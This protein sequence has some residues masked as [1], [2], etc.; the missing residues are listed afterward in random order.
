MMQKK[1][2]VFLFLFL[3]QIC[4]AQTISEIEKTNAFCSIW[5]LLKYQHP[6]VSQGKFNWN[7]Q[8]IVEFN[9]LNEIA[10]YGDFSVEM[11]NWIEK[12]E[13]PR[14]KFKNDANSENK[15][16]KNDEFEWAQNSNFSPELRIVLQK[17]KNNSNIGNYYASVNTLSKMVEVDNDKQYPNFDPSNKA[18]RILFLSSFWNTMK[19]WNVNIYLTDDKWSS[20]LT[21]M[22]YEFKD[23]ANFDNAKDKLFSKLN[24]S[25]AD[26][27]YSRFLTSLKNFPDFGGRIVNDS[28][29]VTRLFNESRTTTIQ[30][31]D[32]IFAIEGKKLRDY[33]NAKFSDVISTSNSNYLKRAIEKSY[34]L[35]S[36]NDSILVSIRKKEGTILDRYIKLYPLKYP[37]EKYVRMQTKV[38]ENWKKM[39]SEIGYL[40]LH[41]IDKKEL[42]MAFDAFKNC[43][44]IIIDLRN[45]PSK[46][47]HSEI[48]GYLYP[49]RKVFIKVLASL[50]PGFGEYDAKAPLKII[51]NPF[52]SGR[53]NKEYFKGKVVL[54]VDRTTAS[55]A[56]FMGMA[57][58]AAPNCTTIGEQTFGAV[59]N[60]KQVILMDGTTIDYTGL[61][62]F[63]PNGK[64]L[65]RNG[66]HIDY[67]ITESA[68]NFNSDLYIEEALKAIKTNPLHHE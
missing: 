4:N 2:S 51:S 64:N 46:I 68:I 27:S 32:V 55:H 39:E 54:L 56:E 12:F 41:Q 17:I 33:Y 58:Q 13:T 8:F 60:R 50:Q 5:G 35:A 40:N 15:F 3:I 44:G 14:T 21:E 22:I 34:L 16:T 63:Y 42:K 29:V 52:A 10:T 65:Q 53:N 43:R 31:G 6:E 26:Y 24:D 37:A 47:S 7:D 1:L 19:Y 11:V 20:V 59:M 45:Y 28:L 25:H 61:G 18:H 49:E 9:T 23:E 66:L 48:T 38:K 57:I 62:A 30:K 36:E 67:Q